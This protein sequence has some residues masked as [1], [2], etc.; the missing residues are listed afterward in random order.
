[1]EHASHAVCEVGRFYAVPCLFVIE[2]H[3]TLWMPADGWVP[4]LGPKHEDAEHLNFTRDHYHVDWRFIDDRRIKWARGL[5]SPVPHG[6]VVTSS[7]GFDEVGATVLKRRKCQR[8]MPDFPA[9]LASRGYGISNSRFGALERAHR[10]TRL[11]PGGICPHR[12]IDLKPFA[13]PD[14]TVI[15]PGH[16]LRWDLATGEPL[17]HHAPAGA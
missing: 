3:R 4:T 10:C 16:G 14:G 9:A 15:C 12:G 6:N 13:K 2:K 17:P 11:K 5:F 1:M 7:A 8:A